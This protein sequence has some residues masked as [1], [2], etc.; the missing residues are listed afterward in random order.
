MSIKI[1]VYHLSWDDYLLLDISQ[2]KLHRLNN[3]NES[4]NFNIIKNVLTI[5]WDNWGKEIFISDNDKEVFYYCNEIMFKLQNF[6]GLCYVNYEQKILTR[7]SDYKRGRIKDNNL[8]WIE[9]D[10]YVSLLDIFKKIPNIIHFVFGLLEQKEEFNLYR[11]IAIKSAIEV[12]KPDILYFHYIYEPYGYWWEKIKPLLTLNKVNPIDEIF[13]NKVYHYSHMAD[14]IRLQ[15]LYEYGGIY[16]DIDTICLTSFSDLL[17]YDCVFGEQ[18]NINSDEIYGLCNAVILSKPN[19]S[20][21]KKLLDSYQSFRSKGRDKYWDE[22]SVIVPYELS[23]KFPS[24]L[25]IMDKNAFFYPLWNNIKEILFSENFDIM[26]YKKIIK[27]NYC[28]HLWDTYS[29]EYLKEL[30]VEKIL[31]QRTLYNILARKFIE[32]KISI[33]ILTWNNIETTK[34]CLESYIEYLDNEFIEELIIFDNN[35]KR[36]LTDYLLDFQNKNNKI[37]IIFS[38]ENLGVSKARNILFDEAKGNIIISLDS[39]CKLLNPEFFE[40]VIQLLYNEKYG[41]VGIE[42]SY[43]KSWLLGHVEDISDNDPNEYIVDHISGCCQ[44]FRKELFEVGFKMDLFYDKFW[45]E[46]CDLSQQALALNKFNYRIAPHNRLIH[47]WIEDNWSSDTLSNTRNLFIKNW[48]YFA[49]KWN[50]I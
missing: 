37:K 11:Y 44:S 6:K 26:E 41:I 30:T 20:F 7:I 42:G 36:E 25:K 33:L 32:N 50:K 22:H 3:L 8:E 13:G 16:L 47:K 5:K 29:Y 1:K 40:I 2:K 49:N 19:S 18:K 45:I 17:C 10:H 23:I 34:E 35:S 24:E 43:L 38:N 27:N 12:N 4:G 31:T 39:N 14:I 15:K 9:N 28:I 46:D 48:E 21:I